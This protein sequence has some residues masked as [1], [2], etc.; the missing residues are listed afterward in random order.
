MPY[1]PPTRSRLSYPQE[2]EE[3]PKK[4]DLLQFLWV[5]GSRIAACA[6][7]GTARREARSAG[8][9][10]AVAGG[11]SGPFLQDVFEFLGVRLVPGH[12]GKFHGSTGLHV[13]TPARR[14]EFTHL[15]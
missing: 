10:P 14:T 4:K 2:L 9:E 15:N 6:Q 11:D 1:N 12:R 3:I 13:R 5:G 8:E 7:P